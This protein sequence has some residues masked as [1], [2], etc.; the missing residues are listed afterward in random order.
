MK[1]RYEIFK[2][3]GKWNW[4][5]IKDWVSCALC[6]KYHNLIWNDTSKD[7]SNKEQ[8]QNRSLEALGDFWLK[9]WTKMTISYQ[10]AVGSSTAGGFTALIFKWRGS[11][12][13]LIYRELLIY[14]SAYVL[15]SLVYRQ[16]LNKHQKS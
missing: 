14:L 1:S 5:F 12:Y 9:K 2:R 15:T 8:Q 4:K 16:L 3:F 6:M 7:V 13:Q 11:I 10:N